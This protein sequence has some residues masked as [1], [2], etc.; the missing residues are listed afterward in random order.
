MNPIPR[1]RLL[2]AAAGG[3]IALAATAATGVASGP[4][5][6]VA[7]IELASLCEGCGVVSDAHTETRKGHASGIG[8]VGGAVVGGLLGHQIGG[9]SGKKATTV[10]GAVAG[11][12]AG[13]AIEKNVKKHTVWVTTITAKDGS[14]KKYESDRDPA[15][16]SGDVVTIENGHPV[17]RPN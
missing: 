16:K 6:K 14:T 3:L 5:A 8:A 13:N 9:G 10:I 15:L 4:P 2:S 11:G 7:G 1:Q 17:K 12:V